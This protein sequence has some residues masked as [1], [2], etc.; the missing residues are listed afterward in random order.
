[1]AIARALLKNP[2]ILILDEATSHLDSKSEQLVQE[3]IW[4]VIEGRTT[5]I[6][7][8]RLATVM[9]ADKII[10]LEKGKI[11]E[12]DTHK[13]LVE[14]GGLYSELFKIQSGAMLE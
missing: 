4:R 7:A 2:P 12:E 14:A 10:V 3:A 6:I 8:H 13:E 1:M 9:K 5:I 11:V